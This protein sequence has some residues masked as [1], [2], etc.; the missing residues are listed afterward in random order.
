MP[1][2]G[3]PS[4]FIMV[5]ISLIDFDSSIASSGFSMTPNL[6][7]TAGACFANSVRL[8]SILCTCSTRSRLNET[9]GCCVNDDTEHSDEAGDILGAVVD[10]AAAYDA[11]K[12]FMTVAKSEV[13]FIVGAESTDS[14]LAV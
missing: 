11:D 6:I 14:R 7:A 9:F 2:D 4:A 8:A 1:R 3:L 12:R 5:N 10:L 13:L